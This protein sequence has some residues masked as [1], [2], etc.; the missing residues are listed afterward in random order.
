MPNGL[1]ASGDPIHEWAVRDVLLSPSN[2]AGPGGPGAARLRR[3]SLAAAIWLAWPLAAN[4]QA[5]ADEPAARLRVLEIL[6]RCDTSP[7]DE[8]VVCGRHSQDR[9]RLPQLGRREAGAG[10]G[11]ARGEA[12]R[13]SADVSAPQPCGIFQGQRRCSREEMA[14]FGYFQGRDPI[15]LLGDLV[16]VLID[17]DADV[18]AP[19]PLP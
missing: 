15:S 13:A 10:A 3:A 17:P 5:A 19:P 1:A 6:G 7:S 4:G 9:Y 2:A 8:V 18:R 12:P 11:Y 16:T 14:E